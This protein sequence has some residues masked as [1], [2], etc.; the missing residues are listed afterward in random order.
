MSIDPGKSS[1]ELPVSGS[2]PGGSS[3]PR[4]FPPGGSPSSGGLP[5]GGSPQGAKVP[6]GPA[7]GTVDLSKETEN[8]SVASTPGTSTKAGSRTS[9]L[10]RSA[11]SSAVKPRTSWCPVV[12]RGKKVFEVHIMWKTVRNYL[13]LYQVKAKNM[14][15]HFGLVMDVRAESKK[16]EK[17]ELGDYFAVK[18]EY[19]EVV[20]NFSDES[21]DDW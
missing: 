11:S 5:A 19:G 3:P 14:K 9:K 12:L 15:R 20:Q 7:K 8:E 21:W 13:E 2:S 17:G 1:G 16:N 18:N 6:Q 10:R 4:G